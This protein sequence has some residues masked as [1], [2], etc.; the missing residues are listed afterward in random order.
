MTIYLNFCDK[1][2]DNGNTCYQVLYKIERKMIAAREKIK[3]GQIYTVDF[4]TDK[5]T[6]QCKDGK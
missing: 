1:P 3:I 6:N 2:G 4:C 5:A